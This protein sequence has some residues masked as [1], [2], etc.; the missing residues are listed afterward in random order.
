MHIYNAFCNS[1]ILILYIY[2]YNTIIY[3]RVQ[4]TAQQHTAGRGPLRRAPR[5]DGPGRGPAPR[6]PPRVSGAPS[7]RKGGMLRSALEWRRGL[8]LSRV[9]HWAAWCRSRLKVKAQRS[10]DPLQP[11]PGRQGCSAA[12][13]ARPPDHSLPAPRLRLCQLEDALP[14][15]AQGCC[16]DR[17][18][19]CPAVP[20]Q[21]TG[22]LPWFHAGSVQGCIWAMQF[23]ACSPLQLLALLRAGLC[24]PNMLL[25]WVVLQWPFVRHYQ[26]SQLCLSCL[27]C[28]ELFL[29]M[30]QLP[31]CVK[32]WTQ[33]FE[34]DS[35]FLREILFSFQT[36]Y[37]KESVYQNL[38]VSECAVLLLL[39]MF[40][41]ILVKQRAL[42]FAFFN[43]NFLSRV[44][45]VEGALKQSVAG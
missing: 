27:L 6:G 45:T 10:A 13:A 40:Q 44:Q 1:M 18:P 28:L 7:S 16:A 26:P 24:W 32:F 36:Y 11:P 43:I 34:W 20:V 39:V 15:L 31:L 33:I 23:W 42:G 9:R 4:R 35:V 37:T 19:G 17:G 14:F 25:K 41:C 30:C 38:D 8:G 29:A 3:S 21:A 12:Q 2:I 5:R 22:V